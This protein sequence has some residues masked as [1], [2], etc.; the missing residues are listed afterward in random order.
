[1]DARPSWARAKSCSHSRCRAEGLPDQKTS[2]FPTKEGLFLSSFIYTSPCCRM[3]VKSRLTCCCPT[4]PS[5]PGCTTGQGICTWCREH[6]GK[7]RTRQRKPTRGLWTSGSGRHWERLDQ[8]RFCF[9]LPPSLRTKCRQ[10]HSETDC[11]WSPRSLPLSAAGPHLVAGVVV[12]R[13]WQPEGSPR[14]AEPRFPD[15]VP[16]P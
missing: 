12:K 3:P 13:R 7:G 1:M 6:S 2:L 10:R 11:Q 8:A 4:T 5:P 9:D 14:M 15:S 16:S